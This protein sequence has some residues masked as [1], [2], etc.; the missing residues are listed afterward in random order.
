MAALPIDIA[1]R[2]TLVTLDSY[3]TSLATLR[4]APL[5]SAH[6][7]DLLTELAQEIDQF[8]LDRNAPYMRYRG[9]ALS[10]PSSSIQMT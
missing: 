10:R 2:S 9:N 3:H 7:Q 4:D 6:E 1:T 8:L 5:A